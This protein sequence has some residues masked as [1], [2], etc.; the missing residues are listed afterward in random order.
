LILV[1]LI[2]S[3]RHPSPAIELSLFALPSVRM[4][5]CAIV[6]FA[7]AF[8]AK[9]LIDVLFLT[10]IWHY[11][12]LGAGL[13]MTPGPL[14]TALLATPAGRLAERYGVVP[15]AA[16]GATVYALACVWYATRV[17]SAP[18]YLAEW[19]PGAGLTGLGIAL[20]FPS[21]TSAA[22]MALPPARYGTGS[23]VNAAARQMGGVLGIA[24]A[25]SIIGAANRAAP[26]AAFV[27]AWTYAAVSAGLAAVLALALGRNVPAAVASS[28]A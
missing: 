3:R 27:H 11:S 15:V 19:L 17:G 25:V 16:A 6:V 20:A 13:A 1:F 12:V 2:R 26:H 14:I 22:V 21:F 5:N 28:A 18:N 7:A 9:I 24:I 4:A 10:S 23:A 8:F